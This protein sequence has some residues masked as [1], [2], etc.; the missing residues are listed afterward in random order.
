MY[1]IKY[2]DK[3]NEMSLYNSK[4]TRIRMGII[5]ALFLTIGLYSL[6]GRSTNLM[7]YGRE[8]LQVYFRYFTYQTL[9][10]GIIAYGIQFIYSMWSIKCLSWSTSK[11]FRGMLTTFNIWVMAVVLIVLAPI[12]M[13]GPKE[14]FTG[15]PAPEPTKAWIAWAIDNAF[16][17]GILI[18]IVIWD[19]FTWEDKEKQEKIEYKHIIM[20]LIYPTIWIIYTWLFHLIDGWLPYNFMD[21]INLPVYTVVLGH[22]AATTLII[23]SAG[24]ITF[25]DKK[26]R[27]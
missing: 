13:W 5:F 14:T 19:F 21:Y 9:W 27:I 20:W 4:K 2:Q 11:Y 15:T 24:L 6:I 16:V 23:G 12:L 17:H 25:I 3:V 18:I 22:L 26:R 1:Q 10:F 7:Y 8:A